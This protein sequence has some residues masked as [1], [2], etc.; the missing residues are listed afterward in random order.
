MNNDDDDDAEE[1]G[2]ERFR[3]LTQSYF[4]KADGVMILFDVTQELTFVNIRHWMECIRDSHERMVPVMLCGTKSDLRPAA[5]NDGIGCVSSTHA[6][7]L[8]KEL[9]ARYIETSA[10]TGSN[11]F[12]A[13]VSLTRYSLFQ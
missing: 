8:A 13:L 10:K 4:R 3:S 2:Q 1:I 6:Q 7:L 9:Q 11:V 5:E 12:E